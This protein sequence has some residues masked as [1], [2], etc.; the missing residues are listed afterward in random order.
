MSFAVIF[1]CR[2]HSVLYLLWRNKLTV[3]FDAPAQTQHFIRTFLFHL[4]G[5]HLER[6]MCSC[7]GKRTNCVCAVLGKIDSD[8]SAIND[9]IRTLLLPASS[10][11]T[12]FDEANQKSG[13]FSASI[14]PWHATWR[15]NLA[16]LHYLSSCFL[17]PLITINA[18]YKYHSFKDNSNIC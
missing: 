1:L 4:I 2:Y 13:L 16:R 10:L 9:E 5:A 11:T 14:N 15:H 18:T 12:Q 3:F 8:I 17:D 6:L 7:L